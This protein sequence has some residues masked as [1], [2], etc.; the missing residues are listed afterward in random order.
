M[1]TCSPCISHHALAGVRARNVGELAFEGGRR[2]P[3]VEPF[4]FHRCCDER[5]VTG[6]RRAIDDEPCAWQRLESGCDRT[7]G[8]EVVRPGQASAQRQNAVDHRPGFV[9]AK[10]KLAAAVGGV[11]GTIGQCEVIGA[12]DSLLGIGRQIEGGEFQ[13]RHKA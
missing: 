8:V 10:A 6:L 4:L 12:D 13:L 3:A 7:I 5:E 11:L 9:G 2:R 1:S